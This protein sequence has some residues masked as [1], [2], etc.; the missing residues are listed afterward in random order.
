[1]KLAWA[2]A[3]WEDYIWWQNNDRKTAR[4]INDLIKSARRTPFE[5]LGKPESLKGDWSGWWFR[6]ITLEHRLVYQA[7]GEGNGATL[8]IAQCRYHY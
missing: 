5:G 2:D 1:M 7:V 6:R 4:K 8:V 3:A